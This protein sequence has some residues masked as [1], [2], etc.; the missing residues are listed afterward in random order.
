MLLEEA[1]SNV[2]ARCLDAFPAWLRSLSDDAVSLASVVEDDAAP[3]PSR[4]GAAS[5]LN[6][7]FKSL[8]LIPD[9]IE[10]IGFLDDA[11]VFRVAARLAVHAEGGSPVLEKLATDAELISEFLGVEYPR[12]ERFVA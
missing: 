2:D 4:R 3:E 1:M 7:L 11:F 5:A 8:D 6:Y 10:D 9:G 12:L